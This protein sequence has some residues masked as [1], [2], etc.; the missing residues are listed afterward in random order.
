[1]FRSSVVLQSIR[2]WRAFLYWA[3]ISIS[4]REWASIFSS[5]ECALSFYA[6]ECAS[7]LC[8]SPRWASILYSLRFDHLLVELRS[9]TFL[10][11]EFRSSLLAFITASHCSI[12]TAR[13]FGE[14]LIFGILL[15]VLMI[16]PL[17]F[18]PIFVF[19]IIILSYMK[20]V[21]LCISVEPALL[22]LCEFNG[23]ACVF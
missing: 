22:S 4:I 7:I 10:F 5:R 18:F 11:V 6:R 19:C 20:L 21:A 16:L 12:I 14:I 2:W 8:S 9:S 13:V 15:Q 23:T 1:M 17:F 3:S